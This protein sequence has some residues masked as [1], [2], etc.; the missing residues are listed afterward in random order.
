MEQSEVL[1]KDY[2]DQ[3]KGA[4]LGAIASIATADHIADEEEIQYLRALAD[5]AGLSPEQKEVLTK[6]AHEISG[7]ELK[8]CLDTLKNSQLK[9]SLVA[10]LISFAESDGHYGPEEKSKI[11]QISAYLGI[12]KQQFSFLDEFV[13]K[14][15]S[16]KVTPQDMQDPSFAEKIGMKEKLQQSGINMGSLT[17][18]L[19][20]I[21]GPLVLAGLASKAL[22]GRR[23]YGRGGM[24]PFGNRGFGGGGIGSIISSLNMGRGYSRSGGLLGKI[25]GF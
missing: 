17:K 15:S 24:N 11:E 18:G 21:V 22:G 4:Y 8:A 23:N 19:I 2:S 3:E 25:L 5:A 12:N 6:A 20:G 7:E 13:T 14:T 9:F 16:Q 10:D 1:L